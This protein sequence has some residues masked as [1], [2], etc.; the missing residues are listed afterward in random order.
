MLKILSRKQRLTPKIAL[1]YWVVSDNL[2]QLTLGSTLRVMLLRSDRK[3]GL[4]K[5][6]YEKISNG[7]PFYKAHFYPLYR[8]VYYFVKDNHNAEN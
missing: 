4:F 7:K 8:S 3:A 1:H 5:S 6:L 2:V